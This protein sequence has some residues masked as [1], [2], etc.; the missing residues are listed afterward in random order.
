MIPDYQNEKYG[1]KLYRG[2]CINVVPQLEPESIDAVITDPPYG[3]TACSWD[4]C[5]PFDVMWAFLRHVRKPNAAIVLTGSEPFSS[6]LR[7]SNIKEY[8]Y[9][10]VWDKGS[11]SN[12]QLA[13]FQPL[14]QHEII[15]VFSLKTHKYYPQGL[16]PTGN[17]Q[18]E[19]NGK[20]SDNLGNEKLG[21][22]ARRKD[23]VQ[24]FYGYP[25]SILHYNRDTCIL[26]PTQKPVALM[27]YL[28]KTYTNP[29]DTVLDFTM[30]SG[31][32]GVAAVNTGRKF[33]GIEMDSEKHG[34]KYFRTSV[35]RIR[36]AIGE[37]E[38]DMFR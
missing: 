25:K 10:W 34:D 21:H 36:D 30:G 11:I 38:S 9:D 3:T 18:Q 16:K 37:A 19:K 8:K 28:I 7:V 35:K 15:S 5:I 2:N 33:V 24:L 4:T 1:I 12:P 26:H 14:K 27:E 17:I 32:T 23:Y 31:T 13:K 6:F 22:I 29:G 20:P